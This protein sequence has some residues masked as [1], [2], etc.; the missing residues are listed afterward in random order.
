MRPLETK[1]EETT[2]A[3]I[4]TASP[5][6]LARYTAANTA[7]ANAM[8]S[9][10]T[11]MTDSDAYTLDM[12][13]PDVMKMTFHASANG[14]SISGTTQVTVADSSTSMDITIALVAVDDGSGNKVSGAMTMKGDRNADGTGIMNFTSNFTVKFTDNTTSTI[15][16]SGRTV[17]TATSVTNTGTVTI[18][19]VTYL[20]TP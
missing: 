4:K 10:G 16:M 11:T 5:A 1:D 8:G 14:L 20:I 13:N 2:Y 6:V 19:G 9:F 7:M 18:D 3:S 17:T 15:K 12:T